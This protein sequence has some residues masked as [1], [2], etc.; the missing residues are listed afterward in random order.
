MMSHYAVFKR[1]KFQRDFLK[2]S[3]IYLRICL[4]G[5][6]NYTRRED[7][8]KTNCHIGACLKRR[9]VNEASI[10]PRVRCGDILQMLMVGLLMYFLSNKEENNFDSICVCVFECVNCNWWWYVLDNYK[11]NWQNCQKS[12]KNFNQ[13]IENLKMS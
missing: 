4:R 2:L 1:Q 13:F 3:W 6:V 10:P 8:E 9:L 7:L 12:S 5:D 11:L